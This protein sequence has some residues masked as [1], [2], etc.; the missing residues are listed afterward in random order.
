MKSFWLIC[1]IGGVLAFV[2]ASLFFALFGSKSARIFYRLLGLGLVVLGL[3]LG[4]ANHWSLTE[5]P[6][7]EIAVYGKWPGH[8]ARRTSSV[9]A[10][11]ASQFHHLPGVTQVVSEAHSD[12]SY[13]CT[14]AFDPEWNP[15]YAKQEVENGIMASG[16]LV[17]SDLQ[18]PIRGNPTPVRDSDEIGLAIIGKGRD[19]D[20]SALWELS[21]AVAKRLVEEH[22][23][24][25]L[26]PLDDQIPSGA[27]PPVLVVRVER[28]QAVRITGFPPADTR[29]RNAAARC[30]ELAE[31]ERAKRP[32]AED[33]ETEILG[34]SQGIV[35]PLRDG[36][37]LRY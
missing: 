13:R 26:D 17:P 35:P 37:G 9:T 30:L 16:A 20:E 34:T 4:K 19:G 27:A 8:D 3:Y 12:G 18:A 14:I 5:P 31:M 36:F 1:L 10:S 22:A 29:V 25:V 28:W 7:Y 15:E 6:P 21:R 11:L 2:A 32:D 33:F 23:L 24:S